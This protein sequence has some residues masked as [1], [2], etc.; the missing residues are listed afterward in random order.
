MHSRTEIVAMILLGMTAMGAP[1]LVFP[2]PTKSQE[3]SLRHAVEPLAKLDDTALAALVPTQSGIFFTDCPN[4]DGGAQDQANWSWS[5]E[6]P[7]HITCRTCGE[8]YPGN[9]RYPDTGTIR[10]RAPHGEHV[11]PY[12][13]RPDGYRIFFR[14]HADYL[15]RE[16]LAR[17]CRDLAQLYYLTGEDSYAR[18]AVVLLNRF[19]EVYPGYACKF[20]YPFRQKLFSP[21][22][23]PHI[24]GIG[25]YRVSKWSWWAYMGISREL[26]Q[27]YDICRAWPP[28][29][30]LEGGRVRQ[31]I[32]NDLIGGMVAFVMANPEVYSNMSP[33]MW[34]DFIYAGRVLGRDDWVV[35]TIT[36]ADRFMREHFLYDGFWKEPAPSYCQQVIGLMDVVLTILAPYTPPA[37]AGPAAKAALA[38]VRAAY[39]TLV[40]AYH[41]VLLP[42]RRPIPINDT[43]VHAGKATH[44]ARSRLIPGVE[45]SV[46][47]AGNADRA[48]TAWL[49]NSSGP[50]HKHN[51]A[52]SI[53]L[54]AGAR[55]VLRDL[56]YTH[57]AWR[58]WTLNMASH[59]TVVVDGLD[60]TS[61]TR[62]RQNRQRCFVTDQREFSLTEAENSAAYA[63]RCGRF[64]RTLMLIGNRADDATVIDV[65]QVHGGKQHDWLLHGPAAETSTMTLPGR[66]LE[67][68]SGTLMN[69]GT[70]FH[71]PK[72]ES[73]G[74]GPAGGFGFIRNLRRGT[75]DDTVALELTLPAKPSLRLRT[76][77]SAGQ[78]AELFLGEAP[79]I[80]Q[81]ERHDFRLPDYY[82]PVLCVRTRGDDLH[83]TFAAVHHLVAPQHPIESVRILHLPTAV[84]FHIAYADGRWDEAVIGLDGMADEHQQ[85]PAGDMH[86]KAKWALIRGRG[87]RPLSLHVVGGES[88]TLGDMNIAVDPG[89]SGKVVHWQATPGEQG[90]AGWIEIPEVLPDIDPGT[91]LLLTFPDDTVRAFTPITTRPAADSTR[92]FVRERPAFETTKDGIRLTAFPQRTISG[93]TVRYRLVGVTHVWMGDKTP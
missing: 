1:T 14:A 24:E 87:N 88:L 75:T 45:L 31:R 80:R 29:D 63:D 72:A 11:Y 62:H 46:L 92:I 60:S 41:M 93:N 61:D 52:L 51:D 67:A 7:H 35:E 39:A 30:N 83:T 85:T 47:A 53:G 37:T 68:F 15:L 43:W 91:A 82:A 18:R 49:E 6:D 44:E 26:V 76:W 32:E 42:D 84:W 71:L 81:A 89:R 13:Q 34:C 10:V 38:R 4:C 79:R 48:V 59:N 77:L 86:V 74:V 56:G 22:D 64:R 90:S 58:A 9:P 57:T 17:Y 23:K 27:A 65:F 16:Y 55:E 25:P 5:I 2:P 3:A 54:Y 12:Y 50:G 28:L 21:Y 69:P 73:E 33:V 70:K 8:T 66:S 20:D 36:R 40:N 78:P 19:A